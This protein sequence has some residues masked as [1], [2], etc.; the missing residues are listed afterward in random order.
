MG[1]LGGRGGGPWSKREKALKWEGSTVRAAAVRV[2]LQSIHNLR[3][4]RALVVALHG[5]PTIHTDGESCQL[6]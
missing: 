3:H 5:D 4:G 6:I 1:Y 2:R